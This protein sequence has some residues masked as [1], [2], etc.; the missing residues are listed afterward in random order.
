MS[1]IFPYPLLIVSLIGM[2]LLLTDFTPGQLILGIIVSL[3]A[4]QGLHSLQPSTPRL[5]RW[6][7]IPKLI[8]LVLLDIIR[9][10]IAVVRLILTEG[11]NKRNSG[12]V[13]I[14]LELKDPTALAI[15]SV[16]VT[17][18]PGT[19]WLDYSDSRGVLMIH[20]FDLVDEQDWIDLIK[21]QYEHLL[22][23]IFE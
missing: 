9:S 6:D 3:L 5:R 10:N 1:R 8:G 18:T 4:A 20:V 17:S 2:W 14:P 13:S 16:I 15:L 11:H 21:N 7:L 23:E 19:A 12:F 22:M